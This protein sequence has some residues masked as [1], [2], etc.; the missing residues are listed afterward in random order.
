MF[1]YN[2]R[3]LGSETDRELQTSAQF[4]P[5]LVFGIFVFPYVSRGIVPSIEKGN[6]GRFIWG[7]E[8]T[9]DAI[10]DLKLF[11]IRNLPVSRSSVRSRERYRT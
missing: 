2:I 11:G 7:T 8:H 3:R 5:D 9:V 1:A 6:F 10:R 4:T